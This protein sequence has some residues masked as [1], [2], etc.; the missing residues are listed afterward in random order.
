VT[1]YAR[2]ERIEV[3]AQQEQFYS[4]NSRVSSTVPSL[5]VIGDQGPP[6]AQPNESQRQALKDL[7]RSLGLWLSSR[8]LV[9]LAGAVEV[10]ANLVRA[11]E[12]AGER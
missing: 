8:E 6:D 2:R 4:N 1:R 3:I 10:E 5:E 12:E 9:Y 7:A 11:T